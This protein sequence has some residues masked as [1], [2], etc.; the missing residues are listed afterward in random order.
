MWAGRE[1][2]RVGE[3]RWVGVG[4]RERI[5]SGACDRGGSSREW[6]C[7]K[8]KTGILVRVGGYEEGG[9]W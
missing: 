1:R 4:V 5:G 2:L 3:G 9:E 6:I 7:L 8:R